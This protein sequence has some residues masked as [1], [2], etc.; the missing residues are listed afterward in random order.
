MLSARSCTPVPIPDVLRCFP[1][2]HFRRLHRHLTEV[3]VFGWRHSEL[4]DAITIP[5]VTAL[6]AS[7]E[8]SPGHKRKSLTRQS[9]FFSFSAGLKLT[10]SI[11]NIAGSNYGTEAKQ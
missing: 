2:D 7:T 4:T 3:E 10:K 8:Q 6:D 1:L 9:A 11:Y 5:E